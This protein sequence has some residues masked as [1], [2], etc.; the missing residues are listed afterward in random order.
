MLTIYYPEAQRRTLLT[1]DNV[2][3]DVE[4]LRKLVVSGCG[5]IVGVVTVWEVGVVSIGILELPFL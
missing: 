3:M 2:S 1:V 4:G 5:Q